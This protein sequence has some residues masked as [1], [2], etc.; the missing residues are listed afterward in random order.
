MFHL[1]SRQEHNCSELALRQGELLGRRARGL[2][3]LWHCDLPYWQMQKLCCCCCWY[4]I[5]AE[6]QARSILNSGWMAGEQ[7]SVREKPAATS[8]RSLLFSDGVKRGMA[9]MWL[10]LGK[11]IWFDPACGSRADRACGIQ[12]DRACGIRAGRACGIQAD[13]ACGSRAGRACGIQADRACR[14][15]VVR[16]YGISA[17]LGLVVVDWGQGTQ[18]LGNCQLPRVWGGWAPTPRN[19]RQLSVAARLGGLGP[20]PPKCSATVSCRAFGIW[21]APGLVVVY[22]GQ[23]TQ[24]LGNCQLPRVWGGWAPTPR[25]ARQLSV[26]GRL[27][28]SGPNPPKCSATVSCRA[29]G[30]VGAMVMDP[31]RAFRGVGPQPPEMLGNSQLPSVWGGLGQGLHMKFAL[32]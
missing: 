7:L 3:D 27:G 22:W 4:R 16:A 21:A 1:S 19:A 31:G 6:A 25:N 23:G 24:M 17:S 32:T 15:G 10:C 28:G 26:A 14:I 5:E 9:A 18:M 20:N 29:F 11:K 13:R 12:A 8:A 2:E 30:R